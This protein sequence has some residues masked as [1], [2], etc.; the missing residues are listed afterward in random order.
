MDGSYTPEAEEL[1]VR[2]ATAFSIKAFSNPLRPQ[3]CAKCLYGAWLLLFAMD[4][5]E[6]LRSA[7]HFIVSRRTEAQMTR[8]F[9]DMSHCRCAD[10]PH[11][12][13]HTQMML[14]FHER[15]DEAQAI[16]AGGPLEI[17]THFHSLMK[18]IT[19]RLISILDKTNPVKLAKHPGQ[20]GWPASL[21]DII[22]PAVGPDITVRSLEQWIRHIS[23]QV[24]PWPIHLL[25]VIAEVSRSLITPAIWRSPTLIATLVRV[26]LEICDEASSHL[27]PHSGVPKIIQTSEQLVSQLHSISGFFCSLFV[28]AGFAPGLV[29]NMPV[30]QKTSI[31]R[32]C[33]RAIEVLDSPLVVQHAPRQ[34]RTSLASDFHATFTLVFRPEV[35]PEGIDPTLIQR[36][37]SQRQR[38]L[39]GSPLEMISLLLVAWKQSLTCYAMSCPE[40]LQTSHAFRR[41]SGC[42]IVSYCGLECQ[43][44][45]WRDHKPVCR[46]MARVVQDGGGDI[47]SEEFKLSCESGKVDADDAQTVVDAFSAWRRTHGNVNT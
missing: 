17:R 2:A 3:Y 4:N 38:T 37:I 43:R 36:A 35:S 11:D 14:T 44:R 18:I 41:C 33:T 15:A 23:I 32:M 42:K 40:S 26:A 45:A 1:G 6:V 46:A 28:H 30:D 25:A 10:Y 19:N 13:L 31:V 24:D 21:D 8:L 16:C 47:H 20:H 12:L 39:N 7:F 29:D 27:S 5:D 34:E 22:I 9:N